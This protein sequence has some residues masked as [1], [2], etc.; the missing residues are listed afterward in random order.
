[1]TVPQKEGT[2]LKALIGPHAGF[3]YSGPTA[4]WAYKNITQ[5]ERYKR[6]LLLGPSHKVSIDFCATT[7]CDEY[8]TPLGNLQIDK[9]GV[10]ALCAIEDGTLFQQIDTKYEENE[11][12]LE[13]H[14]PY[15]RKVFQGRE[16]L[17]LLP[18]M[19][20]QIPPSRSQKYGEALSQFMLDDETLIVVS[21]DFCHW[22]ERFDY[23][24]RYQ[25]PTKQLPIH[26]SIENLDRAGMSLI[27]AHDLPGFVKYL[28]THKNTICGRYPIQVLLAILEAVAAAGTITETKFVR[29]A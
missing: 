8:V 28:S 16:D 26:Q 1:M 6:V 7:L 10:K 24:P 12:S 21:S 25:D 3:S 11:H 2:L 23:Q 15:I 29:Y 5:P 4:A 27:E 14:I 19:V 22:G 17:L 13:M 20:G 9:A 18:V